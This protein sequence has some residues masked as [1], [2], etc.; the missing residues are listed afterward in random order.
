MDEDV[1]NQPV[2]KEVEPRGI[3]GGD[4]SAVEETID[5]DQGK[6]EEET[7][8]AQLGEERIPEV[9]HERAE[10]HEPVE[11]RNR[12]HVEGGQEH[13]EVGV[14]RQV[15]TEVAEVGAAMLRQAN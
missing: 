2:G 12:H 10:D 7:L 14:P 1:V 15:E 11:R 5:E 13:V 6:E 8:G 4:D 3:H 9:W